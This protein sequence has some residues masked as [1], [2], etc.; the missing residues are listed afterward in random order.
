MN[1]LANDRTTA[2]FRSWRRTTWLGSQFITL[3]K[4]VDRRGKQ[5]VSD[6]V[7][8]GSKIGHAACLTC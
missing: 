1:E 2:E 8:F 4:L 6:A 7:N 5:A 3:I